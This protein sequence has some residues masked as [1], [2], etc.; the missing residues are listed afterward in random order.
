M[1]FPG[2]RNSFNDMTRAIHS[3]Q[4]YGGDAHAEPIWMTSA[5]DFETAEQASGRFS[6]EEPGNVYSRFTN[7]SAS[8]FET[9]LAAMEQGEDA[10]GVASGMAAYL[11]IGMAYLKQGDHVLLAGG[12]FGSTSHLFRQ[13]FGNFG[14]T[15]TSLP[16]DGLDAW[17]AAFQP[18]TRLV[19]VETPTNP[20]MQVAD[21]QAL[22]NLAHKHGA[23]LLVDNTLLTPVFQKPLAFGADL[24]LHSA[25]KYIDGQGR[26][27]GGAVVGAK[28]LLEPVRAVLRSAGMSLSPFNAWVF[29]KGLETLQARMRAH[30]ANAQGV[31]RWL[32]GQ[33][34]VR[35]VY[36]T[37]AADRPDEALIRRQQ[38]GHGALFSVELEGG[39]KA[40]WRFINALNLVSKCTNIGDAKTMV[41]HPWSTTHC[42]YSPEDKLN[43]GIGP[44]LI[45]LAIGL[46]YVFDIAEDLERALH[47]TYS[48]ARKIA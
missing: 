12:I 30:A 9:K 46:E 38:R 47:Q 7:P 45:R 27:V 14:V 35:R 23:L 10:L 2:D 1:S 43:F 29:S 26:C 13:Y 6:G 4:A 39:Q 8:N 5:Y 25:G 34:E 37:G 41:T 24:V 19:V 32:E 28:K 48:T 16:V 11:A 21:I 44:G 31:V 17:E 42:K 22:A 15:A 3:D 18:G 40:A 20:T 36:Y 33:P